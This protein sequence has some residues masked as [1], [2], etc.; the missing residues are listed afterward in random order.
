MGDNPPR[1]F[2]LILFTKAIPEC[3]IH[4]IISSNYC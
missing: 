3:P 2:N 1:D 4:A